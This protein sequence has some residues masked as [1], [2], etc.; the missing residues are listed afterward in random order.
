MNPGRALCAGL[1]VLLAGCPAATG[2]SSLSGSRV[3]SGASSVA[4]PSAGPSAPG[5]SGGGHGDPAGSPGEKYVRAVDAVVRHG[6]RVWIET[7]LVR[8]WQQGPG[9]FREAV[10]VVAALARRPGVDGI[11]IADELGYRDGL[12]N[13]SEVSAFLRDSA[14]ALRAAA[15]GRL[16]L[17][18]LIVPE[19]GCLPWREQTDSRADECA[20]RA[21]DRDPAATLEAVD[22]YVASGH[23]DVVNLSAGLREDSEYRARDVD[24]DTAM[25]EAWAEVQRRGWGT[26]VT[27]QARKAL[28][29]PGTYRGGRLAA[30][31]DLRTF[32]DTPLESGARAADVWTWRQGYRGDVVRLLDPGLEDNDLWAGLKARHD[33]GGE[34]WTHLSPS[35]LEVGL[36]QDIARLV[37][38]FNTVLVA[39][40]TG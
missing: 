21:R 4:P 5:L 37:E 39:A 11:K 1:V 15:P 3:G 29:H 8:R 13:P 23:L 33:A 30:E 22:G 31:R 17:V 36:D 34:L 16:I 9:S 2:G 38:V 7:D 19:L 12:A 27:L 14:A 28:A 6:A 25:R 20:Q 26:K 32:L 40:G 18:D 10:A 24:R 35:S